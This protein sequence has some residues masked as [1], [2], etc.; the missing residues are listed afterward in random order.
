[1]IS[2]QIAENHVAEQWQK[3]NINTNPITFLTHKLL[4]ANKWI[5]GCMPVE[6]FA[7]CIYSYSILFELPGP[8][9]LDKSDAT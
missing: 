7:I 6:V 2:Y 5:G 9:N 8:A 3:V 1:M 4:S